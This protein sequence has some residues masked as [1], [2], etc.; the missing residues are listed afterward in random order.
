MFFLSIHYIIPWET[1]GGYFEQVIVQML[2]SFVYTETF[3]LK[4]IENTK[5][6]I[7]LA[8]IYMETGVSI[9]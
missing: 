5:S 4:M 9:T 1:Y 6:I 2:W 7:I 8:T 3:L